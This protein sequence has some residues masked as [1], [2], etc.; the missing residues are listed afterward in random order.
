MKGRL[1]WQHTWLDFTAYDKNRP[2]EH[3]TCM[4]D[5]TDDSRGLHF[6]G[7]GLLRRGIMNKS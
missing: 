4:N 7:R 2:E 1:Y 3:F 6:I 5:I